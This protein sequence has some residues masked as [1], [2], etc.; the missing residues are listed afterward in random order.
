MCACALLVC[1]LAW[2]VHCCHGDRFDLSDVAAG[3]KQGI[4]DGDGD[5]G[6]G[7]RGFGQ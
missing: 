5:A 7:D 3:E 2:A 1:V 6:E 4:G